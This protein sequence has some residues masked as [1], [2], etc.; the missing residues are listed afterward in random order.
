M[1]KQFVFFMII[2]FALLGITTNAYADVTCPPG[3][4]KIVDEQTKEI[5]CVAAPNTVQVGRV[6]PI[7]TNNAAEQNTVQPINNTYPQANQNKFAKDQEREAIRQSIADSGFEVQFG[8]GYGLIGAFEM[9]LKLEYSFA[10]PSNGLSFGL[11]TNCDLFIGYPNSIDWAAGPVVHINGNRF[12][13]GIGLG[14]GLFNMWKNSY[15]GE[16]DRD[17]DEYDKTLNFTLIPRIECDWFVSNHLYLGFG[18]DL[19]I[20]IY[21]DNDD[22]DDYYYYDDGDK[23][24]HL[25]I[26]TGLWFDMH[27]HVGYKF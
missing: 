12:R 14:F 6:H 26:S 15:Y 13:G 27:I 4:Q 10:Q 17:R 1:K 25:S 2:F 11:F 8:M 5:F 21:K 16:Y 24:D 3:T 19:P 9:H 23:D 20:I 7:N 18:L 22:D